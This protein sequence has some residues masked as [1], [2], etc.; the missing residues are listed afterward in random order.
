MSTEN[1]TVENTET[2]SS[3]ETKKEI[4]QTVGKIFSLSAKKQQE[5]RQRREELDRRE[6]KLKE[7]ENLKNNASQDLEA[8]LSAAGVNVEDLEVTPEGKIKIRPP[9]KVDIIERKLNDLEKNTQE[10]K[11]QEQE[12]QIKQFK[13]QINN[14]VEEGDFNL[15]K[16]LGLQETVYS[17]IEEHAIKNQELLD[18]KEACTQVEDYIKSMLSEIEDSEEEE[19]Q[20]EEKPDIKENGINTLTNSLTRTGTTGSKRLSDMTEAEKRTRWREMVK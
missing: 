7:W 6:S 18:I 9:S 4:P 1:E 10:Q 16:K 3:E 12:Q 13:T 15:I 8:Y 2:T 11:Q 19:E 14:T 20:A 5:D 17:I